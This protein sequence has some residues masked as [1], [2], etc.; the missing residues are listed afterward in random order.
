MDDRQL[1]WRRSS[2]SYAN[3]DCVEVAVLPEGL[4]AVRD[5]KDAPHGPILRFTAAEWRAF[6]NGVRCDEFDL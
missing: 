4:V 3:G 6:T 5:S 1:G 2:F